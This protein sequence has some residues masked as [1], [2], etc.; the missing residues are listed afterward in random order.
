MPSSASL[1]RVQVVSDSDLPH[2]S[3]NRA[4][5]DEIEMTTD[6]DPLTGTPAWE[7]CNAALVS[8]ILG[9]IN[10]IKCVRILNTLVHII[11]P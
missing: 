6:L 3:S 8:E 11:R 10:D 1:F 2:E 7:P 5:T 9:V 4:F